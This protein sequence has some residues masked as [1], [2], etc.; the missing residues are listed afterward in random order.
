M[1]EIDGSQGEG[2][3]QVLRTSLSLSM[4]TGQPFLIRNIRAG[5]GKPGLLRQHLTCVEAARAVCAADVTGAELGSSTLQFNPGP[6]RGGDYSFA[7]GS[8]GST[9]LVLQ[10]VLPALVH[11]DAVSTVSVS[12]GTH[13][14]HAPSVDFLRMA[15]LPLLER[16]G[17]TV[18]VE[19]ERH[20]FFPAGGGRIIARFGPGGFQPIELI[21]AGGVIK[22]SA[23]AIVA[24]LPGS[25]ARREIDVL[26]DRLGWSESELSIEPLG[27]EVGPGNVLSVQ[28]Q[29]EN[30]TEVFTGFGERGR[31]AES[32]ARGVAIDVRRYLK[33]GVPVWRFLADQLLLPFALARGGVFET[34]RLSQH[35]L[36]NS[37]VIE[38]FLDVRIHREEIGEGRVRVRVHG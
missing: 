9:T 36:T 2:G 27:D 8:A 18:S 30:A 23:I 3:G 20:G 10:T 38:L 5:R 14:T 21:D 34:G 37:D 26:A 17:A 13:N 11:A 7:V 19:L 25:I 4:I 29:R 15:F 6:I 28:I 24:G 35:T 22:K 32:V 16:M 12:G 31:S 1:I 33:A